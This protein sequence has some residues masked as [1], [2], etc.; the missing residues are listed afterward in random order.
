MRRA[1]PRWL[2]AAFLP[3][4]VALLAGLLLVPAS[5]S[6]ADPL[7]PKKKDSNPRIKSKNA[8]ITTSVEPSEAK[9]GDTVTFKVT[10]K[11]NPGYH[12]YKYAEKPKP[13]G[14]GPLYTTFDFFDTAG[15]KVEG[16]WQAS[17]EP[18]KHKETAW[19]DLPFVEYYEDEVTW[20]IKLKVPEGTEAGKKTLRCQLG[21]MICNDRS[22]DPPGQWTLPDAVLTVL[23]AGAGSAATPAPKL[24]AATPAPAPATTSSPSPRTEPTESSG[25]AESR[26]VSTPPAPV[27]RILFP[28]QER[29]RAEGRARD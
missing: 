6:F 24:A 3:I 25:A 21:Y 26:T 7:K 5:S 13:P 14:S 11:L 19:P 20:S 22:C 15:L 2:S 16:N 18:I 29:D 10:A 12:I 17:K 8:V 27:G 1:Q 23:A 9:P 28:D 4:L